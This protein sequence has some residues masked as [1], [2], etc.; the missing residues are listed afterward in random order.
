MSYPEKHYDQAEYALHS[1]LWEQDAHDLVDYSWW[2]LSLLPQKIVLEVAARHGV[3]QISVLNPDYGR[4]RLRGM[5]EYLTMLI[6][7]SHVVLNFYKRNII[8]FHVQECVETG[9]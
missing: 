4:Y 7:E 8:S 2:I 1:I 5:N 9:I 3:H 6:E